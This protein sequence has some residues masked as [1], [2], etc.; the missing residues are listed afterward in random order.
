MEQG[1]SLVALLVLAVALPVAAGLVLVGRRLTALRR[2]VPRADESIARAAVELPAR[3]VAARRSLA[4]TESGLASAVAGR[5]E[6]DR[7]MDRAEDAL[8]DA[9]GT[10]L[11]M[12][13]GI[14]NVVRWVRRLRAVRAVVETVRTF[15]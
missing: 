1:T 5:E 4:A 10:I 6:L 14:L 7:R 9:R 3:L 12:G 13:A 15:T 11:E 2:E 8:R